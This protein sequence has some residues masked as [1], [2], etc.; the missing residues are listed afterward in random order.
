MLSPR[1][2]A[3]TGTRRDRVGSTLLQSPA[4]AG[5]S[6]CMRHIFDATE[7]RPLGLQQ[8]QGV[9]YPTLPNISRKASSLKKDRT[10]IGTP[11]AV[12]GSLSQY[13]PPLVSAVTTVDLPQ[14]P[15]PHIPERAASGPSSP[16]WSDD[17]SYLNASPRCNKAALAGSP[18]E[19][20]REWLLEISQNGPEQS[21][22]AL[23]ED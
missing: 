14:S 3:N 21:A 11:T 16:S 4:R 15:Q 23:D 20:V 5:H 12:N 6:A 7:Q 1:R 17:A 18:T 22:D 2:V 8:S 10:A 13:Q 9:M 19:R